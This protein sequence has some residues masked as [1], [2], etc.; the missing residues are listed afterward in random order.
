MK[1]NAIFW[2][3]VFNFFFFTATKA[4]KKFDSKLIFPSSVMMSK[5]K[6][7]FH[8]GY[9]IVSLNFDT[10]SHVV[11]VSGIS[12]TKYPELIVSFNSDS[13]PVQKKYF[14]EKKSV[15]KYYSN[16]KNNLDNASLSGAYDIMTMGET[17][18][19][20][21]AKKELNI[22]EK[23]RKEKW[24]FINEQ[25]AVYDEFETIM[26]NVKRRKLD[27][28]KQHNTLF[29]S[30]WSFR[31]EFVSNTEFKADSLLYIYNKYLAAP[32]GNTFEAKQIE[33]VLNGRLSS[34]ENKMAPLFSSTDINGDPIDL[35]KFKSK[36][37]VLIN[38]WATWC[39]P[40]VAEIPMLELIHNKYANKDIAVISVSEDR[41]KTKCLDYI[42]KKNMVWG[43][44]INDPEVE[45]AYG[46]NP[47]L[48]Q[49]YLIDKTGKIIYS[50]TERVD[51][52]LSKLL[53]IIEEL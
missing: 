31:E 51:H 47:A 27:F 23:F 13:A 39:G 41:D 29:Y 20:V 33:K 17:K 5:I 24:Q 35:S 8:N 14:V 26:Y 43:N 3:V 15:I 9:K 49:V 12:Y 4:Q 44:I 16:S 10:A 53:K 6:I 25:E 18:F 7:E 28:I 22:V 34:F 1:I 36:K 46:N 45:A 30:L 11:S 2:L 32:F 19:N 40:C 21:F 52:D 37:Y 42:K 48:P 50:R 38:F